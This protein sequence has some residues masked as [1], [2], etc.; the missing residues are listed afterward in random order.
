MTA[1]EPAQNRKD[2][3]EPKEMNR[4]PPAMDK[5]FNATEIENKWYSFWETSGFF[6]PTGEGEAYCIAIPPPNVTGT[7][8]MG[9]AFLNTL[10]DTLI[11]YQRMRGKRVLWQMG[12]DHAG[13]A[14]Q[15]VV[16]RKLAARG[17]ERRQI[18]RE[19]FVKAVW[20]W[21]AESAGIIS[22][23]LR[24]LGASVDWETER[25]TMDEG[26]SRAVT[27]AF[28]RLSERGYVYRA[29]RLI[30]WDP[31]LLTAVS[32]LEVQAEEEDAILYYV[33]Y[34]F[35]GEDEGEEGGGGMVIA[36]TRPET[37]LADGAV[38]VHPDDPRF[39]KYVGKKVH[40]PMTERV[41][42]VIADDYV[43][44]EFGSG[45]VKITPAHDFNDY[46]VGQRH[47][48]EVIN[49][50]TPHAVMNENAP[51]A[52]RGMDRETARVA[53]VRDLEEV[54]FLVKKEDHK[55]S[56]PRGDRSGVILEP[57]LTD[58]WFVRMDEF[59]EKAMQSVRSGQ[60]SF[61]PKQWEK[62]YFNWLTNIQDWCV[63]R[64]L[65]WG[66]RIP[67][68]YDEKGGVYVGRTEAE[69]REKHNITSGISLHRDEDVLDTWFSSALWTFATMGWPDESVRQKVFNPT[70]VLVTGFDIIFFWVARMMMMTLALKDEVPF[71]EV[72]IHGL[73]RDAEGKKMSK[74]KGNILDPLDVIDGITLT[75]LIKKRT[76]DLMQPRLATAIE[77]STRRDFP[78]GIETHG[79]DALRF[80]FCSLASNGRDLNFDVS[81]C[82]GYRN[83]CNKLWNAARYVLA[84]FRPETDWM[85]DADYAKQT[86]HY[87]DKW[88]T[89]GCDNA[90][91]KVLRGLENYRFDHA[92]DALYHFVW[93]E[94]CDWYV[95]LSKP[96]LASPDETERKILLNTMLRVLEK[97]LCLAHP[98]I[99]FV[100]EEIWQHLRPLM[101]L[102]EES[103]MR[104]SYPRPPSADVTAEHM[105]TESLMEWL[106]LLVT[107]GRVMRDQAGLSP[108]VCARFILI[109]NDKREMAWLTESMPLIRGLINCEEITLGE[110]GVAG[111]SRIVGQG[112]LVLP[113][114]NRSECE[115]EIRRLNT[116]LQRLEKMWNLLNAKLKNDDFRTKAPKAVVEET[117]RRAKSAQASLDTIRQNIRELA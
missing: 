19:S 80:T 79:T 26:F 97:T 1:N 18:G 57:Y 75:D 117:K 82:I 17:K 110:A 62:T 108:K 45:T 7:L 30:N 84:Q 93:H 114:A 74:S 115:A 106:R 6:Q 37:I 68:W 53:I 100:T 69:V 11:R 36:T 12:T 42:P 99:P 65:W 16:E 34:P 111:R 116:E 107:E 48:M 88:I 59:A 27:E 112:S 89:V 64:Q 103:I 8:H 9:H 58:Q 60:T 98:F 92:S 28:V 46:E 25:F 81:R 20:D 5:K 49:L 83:F 51:P 22:H 109:T 56:P 24:R 94:Y 13:I 32:D 73:V 10:I 41:I 91:R 3:K 4:T 95:E 50:F 47:E 86:L 76:A 72:Y 2:S 67:A 44:S 33:R 113:F 87:A 29:K 23:Q 39:K 66:H 71:K 38:A 54:G 31:K 63:S 101:R 105:R 35:A 104:R 70:S 102:S 77:K 15:M 85:S 90:V 52:Y 61:V 55:H 78:D 40:V 96:L 21:K 43:K 14:T